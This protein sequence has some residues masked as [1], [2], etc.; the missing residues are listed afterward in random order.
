MAAIDSF[1]PKW[2]SGQDQLTNGVYGVLTLEPMQSTHLPHAQAQEINPFMAMCHAQAS[3]ARL[4]C[5]PNP[6][7]GAV[8]VSPEGEVLGMGH[9]QRRG[10]AHAEIMALR[11][12]QAAGRD[13]RGATIFVSLEPCSHQG[14]T[15]PCTQALISSGIRRVIASTL[16]PNPLVAGHGFEQLR[17]AG[18]EVEL[19]DG[20]ESTRAL[21][22]GFFSRMIRKR[23]WVRMKV[24]ASLDGKTALNNGL[25]Q[26]LTSEP[27]RI[28]G[29]VWRARA[30]ALLTGIGTILEDN[31]R[32]DVRLTD[33]PR[34]PHLVIVDS[35]LETPPGAQIFETTRQVYIYAAQPNLER[36]HALEARGATVIYLPGEDQGNGRKVD[37]AALLTDLAHREINEL[38]VEAG[39]K[40]NGSLIQAGLVDEL[41]VYLAPKLVG[42]GL[43]MA[44][45]GPL[46]E[47]TKATPLA[48]TSLQHIGVDLRI[49]ALVTGQAPF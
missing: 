26:W 10:G 22:I 21:N 46:T 9:T 48:F 43:N 7:V 28:D 30:C 45:F 44:S 20:A 11:H 42:T 33:T 37:L 23:P 41:L 38:H 13:V 19:G 34:Q 18:I 47:L 6:A 32:L 17:A 12:A 49:S 15:G 4:V 14:H 8:I 25:S 29:H 5:P 39:H 1:L 16:D 40:L 2:T 3:L 35:R 31:P 27:A 36:Q 24:A